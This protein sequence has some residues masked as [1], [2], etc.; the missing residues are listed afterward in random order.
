MVLF[1][2]IFLRLTSF[3]TQELQCNIWNLETMIKRRLEAPAGNFCCSTTLIGLTSYPRGNYKTGSRVFPYSLPLVQTRWHANLFLSQNWKD[4]FRGIC[5][6]LWEKF[7]STGSAGYG[8]TLADSPN[9]VPSESS[10]E[11][12][13]QTLKQGDIIIGSVVRFFCLSIVK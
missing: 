2:S 8:E 9:T 13:E 6:S 5:L 7:R 1:I 10:E 11:N 4:S 3:S 12:E